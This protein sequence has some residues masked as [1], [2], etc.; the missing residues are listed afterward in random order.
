MP[1]VPGLP[2]PCH[3]FGLWLRGVIASGSVVLKKQT[4]ETTGPQAIHFHFRW[5]VQNSVEIAE[6][7]EELSLTESQPQLAFWCVHLWT[8]FLHIC[9]AVVT[10][11]M[12]K[13]TGGRKAWPPVLGPFTSQ[14]C[15]PGQI[16]LSA[17]RWCSR[18]YFVGS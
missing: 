3:C 11:V 4:R 1:C 2:P 15:D 5:L 14:L 8:C 17:E 18:V 10:L 12:N 13:D 16:N 9:P 7:K 6:Q